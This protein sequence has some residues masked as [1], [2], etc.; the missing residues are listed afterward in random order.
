MVLRAILQSHDEAQK[1]H[2]KQIH[3]LMEYSFLEYFYFRLVKLIWWHQLCRNP[4][5][6]GIFVTFGWLVEKTWTSQPYLEGKCQIRWSLP[7]CRVKVHI[8]SNVFLA[9]HFHF[10]VF[11]TP[12]FSSFWCRWWIS[13]FSPNLQVFWPWSPDFWPFGVER[14]ALSRLQVFRSISFTHLHDSKAVYSDV[15]V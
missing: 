12:G 10:N 2:S 1:S 15:A 7:V 14:F 13:M 5:F 3:K 4:Q 8:L 9:I 6:Y 11:P